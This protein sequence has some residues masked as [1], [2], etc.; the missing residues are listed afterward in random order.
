MVVRRIVGTVVLAAVVTASSGASVL[1][2]G[3]PGAGTDPAAVATEAPLVDDGTLVVDRLDDDPAASACTGAPDDCSLRGAIIQA[4]ADSATEEILVPAGT[5]ALSAPGTGPAGGDLEV[6]HSTVITGAGSGQ[7]IIDANGGS[8][9]FFLTGGASPTIRFPSITG[10]TIRNGNACAGDNAGNGGGIYV[11]AVATLTDVVVADSTAGVCGT[12]GGIF[13]G[14]YGSMLTLD[15]SVIRDN[16]ANPSSGG[17][18]GIQ[19]DG[20]LTI[21]D[22]VISGNQGAEVGG[23]RKDPWHYSGDELTIRGSTI[24]GNTGGSHGGI[25]A[26]NDSGD[27]SVV[28]IVNSTISGNVGGAIGALDAKMPVATLTH[29]TIT[30]NHGAGIGGIRGGY[31]GPWVMTNSIVAGNSG[32]APDCG[33]A[34]GIGQASGGGNLVGNLYTSPAQYDTFPCALGAGDLGG[35]DAEP[36]DAGLGLLVANGGPTPTHALLSGSPAID[37]G[38]AAGCEPL[39]QRGLS[40]PSPG[41][42]SG[43][44]EL[45]AVVPPGDVLIADCD[46]PSLAMLATVG[47]DLVLGDTDCGALSL[48]T[49]T[50][51][52]GDVVLGGDVPSAV[53]DCVGVG[54]DLGLAGDPSLT[55]VSAPI[56]TTVGGDLLLGDDASLTDVTLPALETVGGDLVLV[57]D[58]ALADVSVPTLTSV[59]GDLLLG[60]NA[61][62]ATFATPELTTVGGDLE[63]GDNA[64]LSDLATPTLG[65]VGGDLELGDNAS[66]AT[67][68][69]PELDAVGGDLEL[70]CNPSLTDVTMPDLDTIGGELVISDNPTLTDVAMPELD[71]VAGHDARAPQTTIDGGPADPAAPEAVLAF[72]ADEPSIF[73]CSLDGAPEAACTSPITFVG[74]SE[75]PHTFAVRAIDELGNVDPVPAR[76]AWTVDGTAP[77]TVISYAP[78]AVVTET[79]VTFI[80]GATDAVT[81]TTV[82]ATFGCSIDG[83]AWATCASPYHFSRGDGSHTFAVRAADAAGNVDPTPAERTW[84]V[85]TTAPDTTITSGPDA[86][87]QATTATF[88]FSADEPSTFSCS[89]DGALGVA[90]TSPITYTGLAEGE[91]TFAV[92]ARDAAGN[93]TPVPTLRTWIVDHSG[94]VTS[95]PVA[96]LIRSTNLGPAAIPVRID[97][98]AGDDPS[99]VAWYQLEQWSFTSKAW[100]RVALATPTTTSLSQP[101]AL[102]Q[103]HRFRVR[104]ADLAGNVGAWATGAVFVPSLTQQGAAA[105]TG[106]WTRQSA[107][108]ASGGSF[109]HASAAGASFSYT[110]T[111]SAI[112][113]IAPVDAISGTAKVFVDGVQVTTVSLFASSPDQRVVVF[114]HSWPS[115]GSHTITVVVNGTSGHP[116]VSLDAFVRLG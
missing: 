25:Y 34:G 26:G 21:L 108:G 56:L 18:G 103:K 59:G 105:T 64:T 62:L 73:R 50:T 61:T 84:L 10:V 30:G 15:R 110:F 57:G 52:D 27:V 32:L 63:V 35:S 113:W 2:A 79:W 19:A 16:T 109:V 12:G 58:P 69:A 8:R 90:C 102:G 116:R 70:V 42:D 100:I 7:T 60:G 72:S 36:I 93:W 112:A 97:W 49:L 78:A 104:A 81:G 98:L 66:L 4:N 22:S 24:S 85:D 3:T 51:V 1:A 74:L 14:S 38:V 45:Q 33:L 77:E 68:A 80:F 54:G 43:A 40:R 44:Y 67:V 95:A 87:T 41:C 82:A 75:G 6:N 55:A 31:T 13:V 101:L 106:T 23:I 86:V 71:S 48:P 39:D 53:D 91:H 37:L 76:W 115:A 94:P 47:G 114:A 11:H 88:T 83:A 99:G 65:A 107:S 89:L 111:G 17:A 5:Y 29:V 92:R 9:V 20:G 46:D 96:S 28:T